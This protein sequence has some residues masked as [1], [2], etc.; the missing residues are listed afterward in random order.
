MAVA[1]APAR[2]AKA[3]EAAFLFVKPDE[4]KHISTQHN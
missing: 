4:Q 2:A 3:G 1:K